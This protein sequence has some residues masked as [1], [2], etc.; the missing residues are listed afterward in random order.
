MCNL[1]TALIDHLRGFDARPLDRLGHLIGGT[2]QVIGKRVAGV[3]HGFGQIG[4]LQLDLVGRGDAGALDGAGDV[5]VDVGELV[6][7]IAHRLGH[8]GFHVLH[9][10]AEIHRVAMQRAGDL[11]ELFDLAVEKARE[12]AQAADHLAGDIFHMSGLHADFGASGIGPFGH[13]VKRP[14]DAA[15]HVAQANFETAQRIVRRADDAFKILGVGFEAGNQRVGLVIDD[16]GCLMKRRALVLDAGDEASD[17]FLVAAEGAL[18]GGDFLVDDFFKYGGALHR[19]LDAADQQ[20][21]FGA[22]RLGNGGEAFGCHILRADQT[23]GRLRQDFGHIAQIGRP[24]EQIGRA[25]N[26]GDGQEQQSNGLQQRGEG[27]RV[28]PRHPGEDVSIGEEPAASPNRRQE[29]GQQPIRHARR[30]A[31]QPGQHAGRSGVVFIGGAVAERRGFGRQARGVAARLLGFTRAAVWTA[32]LGGICHVLFPH[33]H[34]L[35]DGAEAPCRLSPVFGFRVP[36][37]SAATW[38]G[39]HLG[40]GSAI[41]TITDQGAR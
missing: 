26:Y 41:F 14:D 30:A 5:L 33:S 3:L 9:R 38:N 11:A 6:D 2:L 4:G 8:A 20:I 27:Q 21:N 7:G 1:P 28:C 31:A 36:A 34:S 40:R 37:S 13:V 39:L 16:K 12:V 32:R 18:D 10:A 25:G 29:E 23:H 35:V 22:Y 17:A 15:R 19:V 24:K